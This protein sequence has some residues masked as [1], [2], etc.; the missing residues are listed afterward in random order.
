MLWVLG[1]VAA[2]FAGLWVL[3]RLGQVDRA[4][5]HRLVDSGARLI[6]VRTPEEFEGGHLSAAKNV[7]LRDLTNRLT[8]LEPKGAPVVLYCASGTRS[9][10]KRSGFTAVYDLGSMRRW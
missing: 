2:L 5:A 7:P 4:E 9:I 8:E 3:R 10:L 1:A 6:D